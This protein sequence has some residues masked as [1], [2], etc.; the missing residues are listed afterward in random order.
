MIKAIVFINGCSLKKRSNDE[1][2]LLKRPHRASL[3]G[4]LCGVIDFDK[5]TTI[6]F[7]QFLASK[8]VNSR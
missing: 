4:L 5:G 7:N 6:L 3:K 1:H 8:P 2:E